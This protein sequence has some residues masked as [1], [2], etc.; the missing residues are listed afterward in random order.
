MLSNRDSVLMSWNNKHFLESLCFI[1]LSFK[2]LF[3]WLSTMVE[4]RFL[5]NT[6]VQNSQWLLKVPLFTESK[7]KTTQPQNFSAKT[8]HLF[9]L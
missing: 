8:Q 3:F 5:I 7:Q 6:F 2:F 1:L 4:L 9:A